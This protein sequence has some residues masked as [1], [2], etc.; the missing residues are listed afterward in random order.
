MS[1]AT[2]LTDKFD[3]ALLYATQV[4]GRQ[5][6]KGTSTPYAAQLLAVA[7]TVLGYGGDEDLA[8]AALWQFRRRKRQAWL[9]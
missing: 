6:R 2:A 3:R 8:I 1:N 4:H 7:A 9:S 5:V